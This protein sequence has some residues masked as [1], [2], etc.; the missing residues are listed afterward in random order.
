MDNQR[1]RI[2]YFRETKKYHGSVFVNRNP[3]EDEVSSIKL[4]AGVVAED[5]KFRERMGT[6]KEEKSTLETDRLM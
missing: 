3:G 2:I 1:R 6:L 4:D 5:E